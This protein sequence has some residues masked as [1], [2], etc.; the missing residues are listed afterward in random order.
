MPSGLRMTILGAA[1][2][3]GALASARGDAAEMSRAAMGAR[4]A[5]T[6]CA[7]CHVVAPG[8]GSSWTDAPTFEAIANNPAT[9]ARGIIA[10]LQKPHMHML[11]YRQGRS[12]A[13]DIAAYI[14]SLRRQ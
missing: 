8:Q 10:F 3:G 9:T 14:L 12:H 2:I 4:V 13:A 6:S 7:M 1:L 5:K 11:Q